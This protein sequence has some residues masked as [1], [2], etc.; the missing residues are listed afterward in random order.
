VKALFA[1]PAALLCAAGYA[2]DFRGHS[3][4]ES[5]AQ[6]IAAEG[7]PTIA[8]TAF[9]GDYTHNLMYSGA[10]HLGHEAALW[11]EFV[12]GEDGEKLSFGTCMAR[13]DELAVFHDWEA[14]LTGEYGEPLARDELVTSEEDN[15]DEYY[16]G[17]EGPRAEGV[18]RGYF[19]LR[20]LR[21]TPTTYVGLEA[22]G[23][24]EGIT[25]LAR[26]YSKEYGT[27]HFERL[28]GKLFETGAR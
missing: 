21:E 20:R 6:V 16:R 13:S 24:D 22:G 25:V 7:N 23:D 19:K 17:E 4:G 15:F 28:E 1:L 3:W 18:K 10:E 8:G 9:P 27:E 26:Y 14:A 2:A 5:A 11:L 12:E